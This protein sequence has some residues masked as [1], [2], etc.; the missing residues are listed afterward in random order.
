MWLSAPLALQD[1]FGAFELLQ[2]QHSGYWQ[3][4]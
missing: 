4:I 3:S 1:T 2:Q